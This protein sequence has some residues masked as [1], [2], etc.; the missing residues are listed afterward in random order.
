MR[1]GIITFGTVAQKVFDTRDRQTQNEALTA[2]AE[3]IARRL[4]TTLAGLVVHRDETSTHAHFD[5]VAVNVEGHP[6]SQA[7]VKATSAACRI[8]S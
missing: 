3:G 2:V 8:L 1:D 4:K 5:L 7:T 6:I